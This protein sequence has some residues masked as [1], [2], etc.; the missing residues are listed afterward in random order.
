MP[1]DIVGTGFGRT[2]TLSLKAALELLGFGPCHHMAEV[3][4]DPSQLAD[5]EAAVAGCTVDWSRVFRNYRACVDWPSACF[6]REIA[7]HFSGAKVILSTR[8]PDAWYSSFEQTIL[9][10]CRSIDRIEDPH[11]RA[12]VQMGATILDPLTFPDGDISRERAIA[13]FLAHEAEVK[14]TI[15]ADRLLVFDVREGWEPL[16]RFLEVPVPDGEFPRLNDAEQFK[17]LLG[18]TEA[19]PAE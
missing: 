5:W 9:R 4:G 1:L 2:G 15:P 6:W 7:A 16:C 17:A 14:G 10:V 3:F 11:I 19:V 13:R 18:E 12:T 8:D